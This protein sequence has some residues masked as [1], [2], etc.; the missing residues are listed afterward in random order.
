MDE[1]RCYRP[2]IIGRN[3]AAAA[4]HP[5]AAQAGLLALRAGGNAAD[6]AVATA[7][8]LA[9]VEPMMSGLGGDAYYH[10][11]D[12]KTGR[13]VVFNGTGPA[14]R[15]ATPER[16][17]AG[18][19]RTGPMSAS[20]PGMVA[21]LEAMHRQFGRLP[22]AGLFAEAIRHARDGY[23]ATPHHRQLAGEHAATLRADKRSA[24]VLLAE[25]AAP[26]VGRAIVQVDLA[27]TLE[28]IASSGAECFYRGSLARR[29]AAGCREIGALIAE[30]DLAEFAAERQEPI[31]IDYRGF[32]VLE[33]PLNSTGFVLLEEL[34][35]LENFD[36]KAMGLGSADL[37]HV[38]VE[39]KKL[40]FADRERWGADPSSIDAPLDRLL[41]GDYAAQLAGQIDRRHAA[42]TRSIPDAAGNTTYFCTAD[43][44]GN[45]VSGIQSINSAWGSG[46]T[47]GDTGILLNNRM[48]YWHLQPEHPNYLRPGRRV[49]HTMNPPLVLK[50]GALWAVAGTP[51]AD[52]QVQ[53][54]FQVLSAMLDFG[55]DPQQ[56]AEMPRW[57]SNVPG[58]YAN[59]PHDGPDVLTMEQRFPA[60]IRREL[61]RRGHPVDTVGDLDGPCS[62]EIIRRD[63]ASGMLLAG[64]DPRRDGWALAW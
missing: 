37:I 40:A 30:S 23:G 27:R 64:S 13:A 61:A 34:K 33:A 31:A 47:A 35:I 19:P 14:P 5:L 45:A 20:V 48:A 50:D 44:D 54:N 43:G 52:N 24:A 26:A 36:V 9:V 22:W 10:V 1:M 63:A 57:T 29:L 56:A 17:A 3:G 58:Q 53:I 4:N 11:F 39:A 2:L 8:T 7:L 41:S 18:I 6:A 42:P 59:Y 49:R 28:E 21:G 46:A 32:T 15:A 62:I 38:M 55:P 51:G 16:Y 60:E 25:G 12:A